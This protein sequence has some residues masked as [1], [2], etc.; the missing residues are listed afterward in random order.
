[1]CSLQACPIL[2]TACHAGYIDNVGLQVLLKVLIKQPLVIAL[3]ARARER[4]GFN[5]FNYMT[6]WFKRRILHVSIANTILT[7]IIIFL[8]NK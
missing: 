7:I 3:S 6:T 1:M 2:G 5:S 8:F 4:C